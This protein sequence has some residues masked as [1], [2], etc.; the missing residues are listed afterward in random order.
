MT[1]PSFEVLKRSYLAANMTAPQVLLTIGGKIGNLAPTTNT[2]VMRMSRAFNYAG[3][4]Y[5]IPSGTKL[6]TL[7]GKDGKNYAYN[8]QDFLKYL[9]DKYGPPLLPA[10]TPRAKR[11]LP[12]PFSA[13]R[14]SSPGT[15]RVGPTQPATSPSGTAPRASMR[16]S[17]TT[18]TP[19]PTTSRP[20]RAIRSPSARRKPTF[21]SASSA[22]ARIHDL[23]SS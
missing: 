11:S 16:A 20:R 18:S 1:L 19:F 12:P 14:A 13:K 10:S 5:E 6:R 17:T 22:D 21:G 7:P 3:K 8:V 2:C 23:I 9:A 15:S 4:L